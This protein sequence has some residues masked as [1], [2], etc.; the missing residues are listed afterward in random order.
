[1]DGNKWNGEYIRNFT[2]FYGLIPLPLLP[3]EKGR[4]P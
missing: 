1:M 3:G 2:T 4:N